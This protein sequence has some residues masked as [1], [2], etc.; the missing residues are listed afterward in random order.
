MATVAAFWSIAQQHGA[1]ALGIM[2]RV[3][4]NEACGLGPGGF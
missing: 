2:I 4:A 3:V 1:L